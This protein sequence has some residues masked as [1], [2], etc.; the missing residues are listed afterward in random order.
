M[1][2]AKRSSRASNTIAPCLIPG[3]Q[4]SSPP[5]SNRGAPGSYPTSRGATPPFFTNIGFQAGTADAI[6]FIRVPPPPPPPLFSSPHGFE[7]IY[8]LTGYVSSV[9]SICIVKIGN[10]TVT[11][12][13]WW[14][15]PFVSLRFIR[16]HHRGESRSPPLLQE[17]SGLATIVSSNFNRL[18]GGSLPFF[19]RGRVGEGNGWIII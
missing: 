3:R 8:T 5:H 13:S 11:R 18:S 19:Y 14:H 12:V 4:V 2:F 7:Y 6:R 10:Y 1:Q 15:G 9:N 16:P 17:H